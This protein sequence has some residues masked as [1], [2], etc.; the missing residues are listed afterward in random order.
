MQKVVIV[1]YRK[2]GYVYQLE[3]I[4]YASGNP[5]LELVTIVDGPINNYQEMDTEDFEEMLDEDEFVELQNRVIQAGNN[6]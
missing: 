6:P 3:Y 2:D 1:E 4:L 5:V